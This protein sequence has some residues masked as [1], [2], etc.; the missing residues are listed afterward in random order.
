MIVAGCDVGSLTG[1]AVILNDEK[2]L[3]TSIIPVEIRPEDT[4]MNA[5]NQALSKTGLIMEDIQYVVGTG[6]GR[7]KIP[8][9][10]DNVSE[11]TCHGVGAYWQVPSIRTIVDIGGQDCKVI[12]L[13]SDGYVADFA[14]NDKCAAG[15]GRFLEGV[16]RALKLELE[17]LGPISLKSDNP[18]LISTQCSVFAESEVVSLLAD[19]VDIADIVAGIHKAIAGRLVS[20]VNKVGLKQDFTIAGGVSKNAG[21]V[22]FLEEGLGA[23]RHLPEDPQLGGA[24]GAALMA[25]EKLEKERKRK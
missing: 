3:S 24:L 1:K 9:A 6:Y 7:T 15:T 4:A 8:F 11:I 22:K 23:I 19:G 13:D 12:S 5:I 10:N 21:V 2:I 16:A 14:M 20:M 25:K 18:A 17:E